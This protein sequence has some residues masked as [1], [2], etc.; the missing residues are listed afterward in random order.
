[1]LW[2][3]FSFPFFI[4]IFPIQFRQIVSASGRSASLVF[5][6]LRRFQF[7]ENNGNTYHCYL[8]ACNYIRLDSSRIDWMEYCVAKHVCYVNEF[9]WIIFGS[10]ST[11]PAGFLLTIHSSIERK[12][13]VVPTG[14]GLV[15]V[16]SLKT[17]WWSFR[18]VINGIFMSHMRPFL[19]SPR[20]LT[21][22][23]PM[24]VDLRLRM[25]YNLLKLLCTRDSI[26]E[27]HR[28][29]PHN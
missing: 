5:Y 16:K 21:Y 9:R 6:L 12:M 4:R 10:R 19:I 13:K 20:T 28:R 7:I 27:T 23:L 26:I 17:I 2:L 11:L 29:Q 14:L 22:P 24:F 1:M 25:W 3:W 18:R 15:L 8:T